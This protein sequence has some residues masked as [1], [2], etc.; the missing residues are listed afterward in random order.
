MAGFIVFATDHPVTLRW[1][2]SDRSELVQRGR[3]HD[4]SDTKL[5]VNVPGRDEYAPPATG[6]VV[7]AEAADAKGQC[8]ALFHGTVKSVQHREILIRLDRA[9][10]IVQRRAHPRARVPF[11][12]HTAILVSSDPARFFLAQ[13][14]DLGAGG[15]RIMHRLPLQ[16][17]D[18]FR[19]VFR[20]KPGI[21]ITPTATVIESWSLPEKRVRGRT[22]TAYVSRARFVDLPSMYVTF[23][24]RYVDFLLKKG[25]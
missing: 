5:I 8:L 25:A 22:T 7:I 18:T 9:M 23:F 17:E 3:L 20:P 2:A 4:V 12:L 11:G 10:E 13:P 16:P 21:I 6:T 14:V 1:Q 15:V 24:T 19:L